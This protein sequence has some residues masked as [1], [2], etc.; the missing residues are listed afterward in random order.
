APGCLD[1][2]SGRAPPGTWDGSSR[3]ERMVNAPDGQEPSSD[4]EFGQE[5]IR[6]NL[7]KPKSCSGCRRRRIW[8]GGGR[9]F[10]PLEA[11]LWGSVFLLALFQ[12]PPGLLRRFCISID[13]IR[14][15]SLHLIPDKDRGNDESNYRS[16]AD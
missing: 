6:C 5:H 10:R 3:F 13:G 14:A 1:I 2:T 7:I 11:F 8:A 15:Q 9:S 12:G 4:R 16:S